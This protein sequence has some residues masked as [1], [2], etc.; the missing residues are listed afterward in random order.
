MRPCSVGCDPRRPRRGAATG[1]TASGNPAI[2]R[3]RSSTPPEGRRHPNP[4]HPCTPGKHRCDPRRP[5]RGAATRRPRCPGPRVGRLRSSTPPEGRRHVA[6]RSHRPS[7]NLLRSSTPPEGRRHS[8]LGVDLVA[9]DDVAILDAP[10]GAPPRATMMPGRSSFSGCDPRRPR[11]GAATPTGTS[12]VSTRRCC[13]PRR[14]RRGAAT[15]PEWWD[16]LTPASVAILDAPGG[17]PPP[18]RLTTTT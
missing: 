17:A 14:P 2:A 12:R 10:G 5:R 7:V 13:D 3:L 8:R 16:L 1:A 9:V 15:L 18:A 4:A 11:R 6:G